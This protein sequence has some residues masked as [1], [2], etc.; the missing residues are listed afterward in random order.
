MKL[1]LSSLIKFS[2][3]SFV[4]YLFLVVFIGSTL[5]S[6]FSPN[7][8]FVLGMYGHL[9]TRLK[10]A[11]ELDKVNTLILGSSHAYRG[12]DTRLIG[13]PDK[14][15]F[16]LGSS[17]QT[18][19]HTEILVQRYLTKLKPEL[20]I[21]EIYPGTFTSD[22]VES[23]LDLMSNG[24][25]DLTLARI[26]LKQKNPAV[27]NTAIYALYR[28]KFGLDKEFKQNISENNDTYIP[29]GFVQSSIHRFRNQAHV[30]QE[31]DFKPI[32]FQA[33]K[34]SMNLIENSGAKCLLV[35]SPI[36]SRRY[37]SYTNQSIFDSIMNASGTYID[38]NPLVEL[39][40]SLHFSDSHHL[41]QNG[42]EIYNRKLVEV[43]SSIDF[44]E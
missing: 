28:E 40:D 24:P 32:Q 23:T 31:W 10:E 21:Y 44:S 35:Y 36:T 19:I 5:P 29:G 26:A 43:L 30:N 37:N 41:N 12:I 4:G 1:F 38:F 16:N 27:F 20:V 25:M 9:H 15:L 7:I 39:D 3:F 22:G 14:T 33:F 34:R 17:A 6:Y 13:S 8:R 18:P 11:D 2:A 42:V